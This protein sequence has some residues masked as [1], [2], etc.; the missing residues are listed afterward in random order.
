MLSEIE[1]LQLE[2]SAEANRQHAKLLGLVLKRIKPKAQ[3]CSHCIYPTHQQEFAIALSEYTDH[4]IKLHREKNRLEKNYGYNNESQYEFLKNRV[5]ELRIILQPYRPC[6]ICSIMYNPTN[7]KD[8]RK[9]PNNF[10]NADL[11]MLGDFELY[12][13]RLSVLPTYFC[14]KD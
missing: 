8:N 9:N 13:S 10:L 2:V 14:S 7:R 6:Q 12:Y 3:P 1:K 4:V 11:S 5:N